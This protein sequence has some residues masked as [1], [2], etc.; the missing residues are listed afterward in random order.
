MASNLLVQFGK[1]RN[2]CT[3]RNNAEDDGDDW[4]YGAE[5]GAHGRLNYATKNIIICL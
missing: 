2:K 5:F 4:C 1:N 3:H